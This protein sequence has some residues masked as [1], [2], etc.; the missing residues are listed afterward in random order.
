MD[1]RPADADGVVCH[2]STV[3]DGGQGDRAGCCISSDRGSDN[4]SS[5]DEGK[6]EQHRREEDVEGKVCLEPK[7]DRPLKRSK[8]EAK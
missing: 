4:A 1:E 2:G 8:A 7:R 5:A 6:K 3:V